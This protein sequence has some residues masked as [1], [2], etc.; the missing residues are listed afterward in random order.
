MKKRFI[1][2]IY[3]R[4]SRGHG[5]LSV[6]AKSKKD[7]RRVGTELI[8]NRLYKVGSNEDDVQTF[9]QFVDAAAVFACNEYVQKHTYL[10]L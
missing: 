6:Y 7:A 10:K 1:L 5:L 8:G 9:R 2:R 4:T 3:T